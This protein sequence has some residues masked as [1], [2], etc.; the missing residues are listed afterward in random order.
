MPVQYFN[1]KGVMHAFH[2]RKNAEFKT[3]N[4]LMKERSV[5]MINH[6]QTLKTLMPQRL[7]EK[8]V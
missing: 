4:Y 5:Q 7:K 8:E 3:N 2:Q 1:K 6:E